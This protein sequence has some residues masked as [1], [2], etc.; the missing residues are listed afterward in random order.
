[1]IPLAWSA[2]NKTRGSQVKA[3]VVCGICSRPDY[4]PLNLYGYDWS[5]H[6]IKEEIQCGQQDPDQCKTIWKF[7][8]F[9]N[10]IIV[11]CLTEIDASGTWNVIKPNSYIW[12][13]MMQKS[14]W[15]R[16]VCLFSLSYSYLLYI[17]TNTYII[18]MT[19][20]YTPVKTVPTRHLLNWAMLIKPMRS[21]CAKY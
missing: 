16:T 6:A 12:K 20:S 17:H 21:G 15:A 18:H 7:G 4:W 11:A 14:T 3:V 1:M 8:G 5:L 10:G 9:F 19:S 13:L 2:R